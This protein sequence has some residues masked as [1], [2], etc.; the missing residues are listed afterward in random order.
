MSGAT[1]EARKKGGG[2]HE[3]EHRGRPTNLMVPHDL[4]T[5]SNKLN[6]IME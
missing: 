5:L 3:E 2:D 4:A 1:R 6:L